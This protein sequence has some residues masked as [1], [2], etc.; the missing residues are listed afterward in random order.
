MGLDMYLSAKRDFYPE[1][2]KDEK[3]VEDPK[4]KSIRKLFPEMFKTGNL[5]YIHLIFEVGYWRKANAIHKWFVDNV[6]EGKDDCGD[7]EVSREDLLRLLNIC[8]EIQ[9]NTKA[10]LDHLPTQEGF[11]FGD[12]GYGEDYL[13]D[14][15]KTIEIIN[16]CLK[17]PK[18]WGFEYHSSW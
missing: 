2:N 14:I 12:T 11:F 17:L 16:K 5:D 6:Q 9:K 1:Y 8:E 3:K 4:A 7:Y 10:A 18:E 15:K 13:Y